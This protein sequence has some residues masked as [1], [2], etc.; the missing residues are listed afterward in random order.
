MK[1]NDIS[2]G[3]VDDDELKQLKQGGEA[4]NQRKEQGED[5][6]SPDIP[7]SKKEKRRQKKEMHR[8]KRAARRAKR[9]AQP[10]WRKALRIIIPIFVI[11]VLALVLSNT[12]LVGGRT[13][14]ANRLY[15]T[16]STPVDPEEVYNI[17]PPDEE[18]T[19]RV[20]AIPTYDEEDTWAVYIYMCGS[21]L[22]SA[23]LNELSDI[24]RYLTDQYNSEYNAEKDA[25]QKEQILAFL[26]E[27]NE[28]GLDLPKSMYLAKTESEETEGVADN[29]IDES[30]PEGSATHDLENMLRVDL[31]EN[32]KVVIQTG[33]AKRWQSALVNSNR[34]DIL[35]YDS[36]GIKQIEDN[37]IKNMGD[38]ST[39]ADF[40]SYCQ[41]NYP[42]D[43]QVL[44]LYNHGGGPF[45]ICW[46]EIYG[47]DNLTLDELTSAFSQVYGENPDE[48][49]FELIACHACLMSNLDVLKT[50]SPYGSYFCAGEEILTDFAAGEIPY[51]LMEEFANGT[52]TNG[53][54]IGK[55]A[56]D[57]YMNLWGRLGNDQ[58]LLGAF[59]KMTDLSVV[60][61]NKVDEL[62]SAYDALMEKLL[63]EAV[64][65]PASM[66]R[67]TKAADQSVRFA[68]EYANIYNLIDL[69][70]FID[71][72]EELYPNEVAAV[73][74]T[75]DESVLYHRGTYEFRDTQGISVY[76]PVEVSDTTG[77]TKYLQ[78]LNDIS[79][80]DS[81]K[82]FYYY[83]IAGCLNDEYA[84]YA[85]Q[86]GYGSAKVLNTSELQKLQNQEITIEDDGNY[87]LQPQME[88]M[89][90]VQN[91]E[92]LLAQYDETAEKITY[93]GTSTDAVLD[94]EGILSTEFE[95]K[96]I[97]MD[98]H[99]L[100]VEM[101]DHS[102]QMTRY[103]SAVEINYKDYYL[104]LG[105]DDVS[106]EVN[107]LGIAA[108]DENQA[109]D[110]SGR[111]LLELKEG[112]T[113][114][115][116][117]ESNSLAETDNPNTISIVEGDSF[118]FKEDTRF[119]FEPL[120]DGNYLTAINV[121]DIRGDEY[122]TGVV[123][124]T[125]KGGKVTDSTIR[126]DMINDVY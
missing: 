34:S 121:L 51:Y 80:S 114:I 77:L 118:K 24:T 66:T 110:M 101:L 45:G 11:V 57:S 87:H 31:P 70:L 117:F 27:L 90:L 115:P 35:L 6:E 71:A 19:A 25:K 39:L 44:I 3:V 98:G 38:P 109:P 67:V 56:T 22:E 28:K 112:D 79:E 103:R 123:E 49:P 95:G 81:T 94:E 60:D 46:D 122:T 88:E 14:F 42:A 33:G 93:F 13:F 65:D 119:T 21:N 20:E 99:P 37:Q 108:N 36:T 48:K 40:M 113:V 9:R 16:I 89:D 83:K 68:E 2:S 72:L 1:E 85:D 30:D 69:G 43:H 47:D 15:T 58:L 41:D 73:K 100:A 53:A 126:T 102:G 107:L 124:M 52:A 55:T 120:S 32:V 111:A 29:G 18:G 5:G 91:S 26:D 76:F 54:R 8:A 4:S 12:F 125:I 64:K 96:W 10:W 84:A 17:A 78:Y 82:A 86:Q 61:L 116:L 74:S 92:F 62:Y 104:I 59:R 23:G 63:E 97:T 105:L 50:F 75:L 106:G 7:V